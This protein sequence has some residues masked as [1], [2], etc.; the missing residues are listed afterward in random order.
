MAAR[1]AAQLALFFGQRKATRTPALVIDLPQCPAEP[2]LDH[3][4][5]PPSAPSW[6]TPRVSEPEK[7]EVAFPLENALLPHRL[8]WTAK[9]YQAALIGVKGQSEARQALSRLA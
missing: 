4:R 3:L 9:V 8:R 6:S 5:C 7:V 2:G 1:F